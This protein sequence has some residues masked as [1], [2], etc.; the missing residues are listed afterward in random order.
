MK[1]VTEDFEQAN[2]T[3]GQP[4]QPETPKTGLQQQWAKTI[5]LNLIVAASVC[6]ARAAMDYLVEGYGNSRI[7]QTDDYARS[8]YPF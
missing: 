5:V 1:A 7:R 6:L 3:N 8:G 4:E 2:E